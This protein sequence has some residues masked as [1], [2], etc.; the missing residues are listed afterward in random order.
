[1]RVWRDE[2]LAGVVPGLSEAADLADVWLADALEC[3]L[4]ACEVPLG[5]RLALVETGRDSIEP[6]DAASWPAVDESSRLRRLVA[7]RR[8]LAFSAL[9]VEARLNRVLRGCHAD[10]WSALLRMSPPE[11]FRLAPRLLNKLEWAARHAELCDRVD[12]VFGGR[13]EL[14]GAAGSGGAAFPYEFSRLGPSRV[15]EAVEASAEICCFLAS[16][17]GEDEGSAPRV[18]D[19]ARVLISRAEHVQLPPA[20]DRAEYGWEWSGFGDFPPDIIGS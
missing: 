15:R 6:E 10:E 20:A 17:I 19:A 1:M 13:D 9:A 5:E 18:R 14:V 2:G 16:L 4:D 7:C 8:A 12:E 3:L 11:R